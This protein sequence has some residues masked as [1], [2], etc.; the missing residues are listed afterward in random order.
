M[1]LLVVPL[2]LSARPS[3]ATAVSAAQEVIAI[4]QGDAAPDHLAAGLLYIANFGHELPDDVKIQLAALGFDF[5]RSYVAYMRPVL[6]YYYDY[7]NFRIHYDLDGTGPVPPDDISGVSGVP[8]YVE[9]VAQA[10]AH[11]DTVIMEELNF[12]RPPSDQNEGGSNKYDIYIARQEAGVYAYTIPETEIGDNENSPVEEVNAWS[13]YITIRNEWGGFPNTPLEN[14]RVTAAHEYFHAV[15][16]GID[17]WDADQESWLLEATAVL[18]EEAVYDDINDCYQYMRG[19]FNAPDVALDFYSINSTHKYGSF[20]YFQ[21]I[22]EHLGGYATIHRIFE[23][24]IEYD[25]YYGD[26]SRQEITEALE[27]EGS[28]FQDALNRMVVANLV[29]SASPAAGEYSY[30]EAAGYPVSGP[31]IEATVNFA[32]DDWHSIDNTKLNRYASQ[33]YKINTLVP[34]LVTLTNLDG[35]ETDLNLIAI[36]QA[37][38]GTVVV[39]SGSMLN[40]QNDWEQINLA[41]VSQDT[42]DRDWDFNLTFQNGFSGP[43]EIPNDYSVSRPGPN[44]FFPSSGKVTFDLIARI[45]QPIQIRIFNLSG[46]LVEELQHGHVQF[47]MHQFVWDG[48]LSDGRRAP[49]GIYFILVSGDR[50]TYREKITLIR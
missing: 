5:S 40:I 26:Y 48:Y 49:S 22:Q 42:L 16:Y 4:L 1:L 18:M 46:Q 25:S 15:Q 17:A 50:L 44:P 11:T 21:Y 23:R 8:D 29:M 7:Q 41:I 6:P 34:V 9:I 43:V 33:Y 12:T 31:R 20:I 45:P 2:T 39:E 37:S 28:D 10:F 47:G 13:T 30:V 35:P 27:P 38:D 32:P 14:I 19:W 36:L 3:T 24:S